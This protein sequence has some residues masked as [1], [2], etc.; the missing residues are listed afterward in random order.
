MQWFSKFTIRNQLAVLAAS[1]L[2]LLVLIFSVFYALNKDISKKKN[3]EYTLNLLSQFQQDVAANSNGMLKILMNIAYNPDMQSYMLENEY[4]KRYENSKKISTVLNNARLMKDGIVDVIVVGNSG[5][6]FSTYGGN[7]YVNR[8]QNLFGSLPFITGLKEINYGSNI[9]GNQFFIAGVSVYGIYD[10][11]S[12]GKQIGYCYLVIDAQKITSLSFP[13]LGK[14]EM[15]FYFLDRDQQIFSSNDPASVGG[16]A[17]FLEAAAALDEP[18]TLTLHGERQIVQTKKLPEIGGT[19]IS[20]IPEKVLYTEIRD[21]R[22]KVL[23]MLLTAIFILIVPFT[24]IMNNLIKP[25]RQ[26]TNFILGIRT[27]QTV[28][29]RQEIKLNGYFEMTILSS[30]LNRMFDE[31]DSLTQDLIDA[32]V[33][34]YKAELDKKQAELA[35]LQSQINPHFLYNTFETIKGMASIKGV[36]EIKDIVQDLSRIF[37]YSIKGSEEVSLR[38]ELDMVGA[39]LRIQKA[40]FKDRFDIEMDIVPLAMKGKVPKMILQPIVENAII[41]GLEPLSAKGK[42]LIKAEIDAYKRLVITVKDNGV[43]MRDEVL[44]AMNKN[45]DETN[46]LNQHLGMNNV[47]NRIKFIYGEPYGLSLHSEEN[48]G[49]EVIF[50]LPFKEEAYV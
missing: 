44:E 3:N 2:I 32:D 31:I 13:K 25:I 5:S 45:P 11:D 50:H 39:Y 41:H 40:R 35:F 14:E 47:A 36:H 15:K 28:T 19:L 30:K 6:F 46:K 7:E 18:S 16:N 20:T 21:L 42:L 1:T 48:Q 29:P 37:R 24:L 8:Y 27:Q 9:P 38:E 17:N 4:D 26:M 12:I 49:T 33:Q 43:G 22:L 23:Y 34:L 10:P